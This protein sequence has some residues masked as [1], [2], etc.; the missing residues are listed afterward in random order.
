MSMLMYNITEDGLFDISIE[1][2]FSPPKYN[3]VVYGEVNTPFSLIKDMIELFPESTYTNIN[4]RWLDP[5][6]GCGYYP[7]M[8][9]NKLMISLEEK[10]PNKEQRQQHIIENM[11]YMCEINNLNVKQLENMFTIFLPTL[12]RT[13]QPNIINDNFLS[14]TLQT[15]TMNNIKFDCI[16]GNPPY[17]SNGIKKVPTNT[18]KNK[19]NDGITVWY[20]FIRH[21]LTLLKTYGF[22]SMIVPVIWMKQDKERMYNFML[23][24][25][26]HKLKSYTNTETNRI[27]KGQAQTPTCYFLL[28]NK[29][30][31]IVNNSNINDNIPFYE[32]QM[33]NKITNQYESYYYH[34]GEPLPLNGSSIINKIKKYTYKYGKIHYKKSNMITKGIELSKHSSLTK[35][36]Y[37][38]IKTCKLNNVEP[39]LE[40]EYSNKPCAYYGIK[41]IILAHKM[42]G[43]AYIDDHGIYGISNRDNYIIGDIWNNYTTKDLYTLKTFFDTKLMLFLFETT[44]YRMKYLERY[45]FEYIPNIIKMMN[46]KDLD[47][48][49]EI[50][51]ETVMEFFG[52]TDEEIKYVIGFHKKEYMYF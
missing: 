41:K 25:K 15:F 35:Y 26:I 34:N 5:A 27:F 28:Q 42:Y 6:A 3:K 19:K 39:V 50:T 37:P 11:L 12:N 14:T 40:L 9:Y 16:I 1:Q 36:K 7:I 8:L 18:T 33:Y 24:Y 4:N 47:F 31:E 13:T 17:N 46:D 45:V 29:N 2:N 32:I 10:I 22:L 44:R 48:P 52:L 23:N 38:N 49:N 20:D 30:N 43:F 21:S 51:D